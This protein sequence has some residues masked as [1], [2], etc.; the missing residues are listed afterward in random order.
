MPIEI[1]PAVKFKDERVVDLRSRP[2]LT[3]QAEEEEKEQCKKVASVDLDVSIYTF[4][5]KKH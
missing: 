1:V 4:C 2:Y 5:H 3:I